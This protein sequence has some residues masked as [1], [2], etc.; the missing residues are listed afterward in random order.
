M[1]FYQYFFYLALS[2]AAALI[3]FNEA[4]GATVRIGALKLSQ[5]I[6]VYRSFNSVMVEKY[7]DL[8][9]L[10]LIFIPCLGFYFKIISPGL[11]I[12]LILAEIIILLILIKKQKT[13]FLNLIFYLN[14]LFLRF[15]NKIPWLNKKVDRQKYELENQNLFFPT[16]LLFKINCL[17][18]LKILSSGF[19][20]FFVIR[21]INIPVDLITIILITP[22]AQ[23]SLVAA[24]TPGGLG[25]IEVG[26][27]LAFKL[28]SL[29]PLDINNFLI[30]N[31]VSGVFFILITVLGSY[32]VYLIKN[33][34]TFSNIPSIPTGLDKK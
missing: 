29:S 24:F 15:L 23:L 34:I 17:S 13:K 20:A 30:A 8:I 31:R 22:I 25:V 28:I 14:K 26:W 7:L 1:P 19:I 33:R 10:L 9:N 27:L 2:Y 21:A 5:Q 4:T 12:F 16:H 32:V 18:L 3:G 6:S 11:T